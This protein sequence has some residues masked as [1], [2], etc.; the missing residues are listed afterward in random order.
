MAWR[1]VI[2]DPHSLLQPS[3]IQ[4]SLRNGVALLRFNQPSSLNAWS[5]PMLDAFGEEMERTAGS[6]D[7][8][9][10]ILTGTGR[11]YSTGVALESVL[12][13]TPASQVPSEIKRSN[14][15][16]FDIFLDYP[17]P[18]F[19]A[20]NGPAVG[21]PVT[22]AALC[23]GIVASEDATFQTPCA[24]LGLVPDGCSSVWFER[25]MS[26]VAAEAF[27]KKGLVLDAERARLARLVDTVVPADALLD[28]AQGMAEDWVAAGKPRTIAALGVVDEL[29]R[30]NA[31]ESQELARAFLSDAFLHGIERYT[32]EKGQFKAARMILMLR[33]TRPVWQWFI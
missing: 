2:A 18:L 13:H 11:A 1:S 22:S 23:D 10:T 5:K 27:L 25:K 4:S 32:R 12:Q 28:T 29:K 14:R 31:R 7:V 9:A 20:V 30:V 15:A 19:V 26:A 16:L 33:L 8:R 17:K 21:A 24:K 3:L 6:D